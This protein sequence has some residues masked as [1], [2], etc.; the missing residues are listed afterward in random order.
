MKYKTRTETLRDF[1]YIFY[2]VLFNSIKIDNKRIKTS[3]KIPIDSWFSTM[4]YN[5]F[6]H[7]QNLLLSNYR[8]N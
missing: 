2:S 6:A 5:Q 1:D 7:T 8:I 3:K 4:L